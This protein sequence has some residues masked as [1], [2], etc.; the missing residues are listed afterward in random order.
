[1]KALLVIAA[2]SLATFAILHACGFRDDTSVLSG[3]PASSA[4]AGVAY[5]AAYFG[6]IV[7]APV[8]LLAAAVLR[9]ARL[10]ALKSR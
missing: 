10:V 8:L 6:A 7:I 1:M 9:L 4:A 2:V 5:V 3:A